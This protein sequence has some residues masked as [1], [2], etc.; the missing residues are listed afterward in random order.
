MGTLTDAK[1]RLFD[2]K[3]GAAGMHTRV[4]THTHTHRERERERER[5]TQKIYLEAQGTQKQANHPD[6]PM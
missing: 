3:Y 1:G 5:H 4:H 2:V 6:T